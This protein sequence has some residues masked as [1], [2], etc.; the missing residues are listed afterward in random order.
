MITY[1][2]VYRHKAWSY[3]EG[4][5]QIEGVRNK[6]L[7]KL[8]GPNRDEIIKDWGKL[9]NKEMHSLYK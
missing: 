3:S 6:V 5:A 9:Q 1:D 2:E 4:K 7:R 8:H